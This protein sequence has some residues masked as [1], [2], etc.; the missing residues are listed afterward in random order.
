MPQEKISLPVYFISD[1]HLGAAPSGAIP[2]REERVIE[3]LQRWQGLASHVVFVGDTFE[4]WMEY[5]HYVSC[6]HFR[7]LRALADLVD[8]GVSVHLLAG[9]HDFQLD[10]FFPAQ[11]GVSVHHTLL[12]EVQGLRIWCQHGDGAARSDWKYRLARRILRNPLDVWLFRMLHPDWGMSLARWVGGSSR[13]INEGAD[14]K[15]EEYC[16]FARDFLARERYDAIVLAHN[17]HAGI[18]RHPEGVQVNCGQWLF[19]LQYVRLFDGN[20]HLMSGM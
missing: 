7:F 17:H 13:R 10:D 15:E 18:W 3:L 4:F 8:S 14:P 11:L 2:Y 5:R 12:L 19:S 20:F 9:N 6:H 16:A 1:L